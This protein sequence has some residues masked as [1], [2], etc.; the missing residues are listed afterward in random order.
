MFI[1][2]ETLQKA[3]S[4]RSEMFLCRSLRSFEELVLRRSYKHFA[5]NGA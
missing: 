2:L 4:F 3:S 5:P 1:D